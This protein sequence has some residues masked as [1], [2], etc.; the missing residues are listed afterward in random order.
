LRVADLPLPPGAIPLV[1]AGRTV[2]AARPRTTLELDDV[3]VIALP[4]G[5]LP[6]LEKALRKFDPSASA[7]SS[8]ASE[9]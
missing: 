6:A 2:R 5:R 8:G 4:G 1:I 7:P 3:L 9:A